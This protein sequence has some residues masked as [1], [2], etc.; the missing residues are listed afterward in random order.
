MGGNHWTKTIPEMDLFSVELVSGHLVLHLNLGSGAIRV[1]ASRSRL[2]DKQ[3]H[4]MTLYRDGKEGT[5][6]VDGVT[7]EFV[8]PGEDTYLDLQGGLYLGGY[9]GSFLS[10]A[11]SVWSA[12]LQHGFVGCVQGLHVDGHAIDIVEFARHQDVDD[13]SV[14]YNGSQYTLIT[15]PHE[16]QSQVE[17]IVLRFR[18]AR[19]NGFLFSTSSEES[20]DRLQAA[21]INGRLVVTIKVGDKDKTIHSGHNLHDN[22][23]HSLKYT[24]RVMNLLIQLDH[25]PHV[26]SKYMNLVL[27]INLGDGPVRIKDYARTSINDNKWHAISIT[28]PYPNVH[29]LSVDDVIATAATSSMAATLDL[30]SLFYIG[31][32]PKEVY[33]T[34]PKDLHARHGFEGCLASLEIN[35]NAPDLTT[36][37][38]IPSSL[39]TPG[40]LGHNNKCSQHVCAN[41][42]VCVQ[43][44]NSFT[45]DCDMTSYT[46]PTCS[47]ESVAYEF[48]PERGIITFV[49]P[50]DRRPEMKSD[51]LAFAFITNHHDAVI[52]RVESATSNDYIEVEIVE[53]NIFVVYNMGTN[54]NPIGETFVKV[55]DGFYHVV[56][57]TRNAANSTLQLDDFNLQTN[58]PSGNQLSVFNSVGNIQIGGKWNR[59]KQRI[60]RPFSGV[61][62]GLVLNGQR[63]LDLAADKDPR[64]QIRGD[65]TL[66]TS[67][68]ERIREPLLQKMQQTPPDHSPGGSDDLVFS[69]AGSGCPNDDEDSC[70]PSFDTSPGDDLITPVYVPPTPRSKKPLEPQCRDDDED[71][72]TDGSG[73]DRD[74]ISTPELPSS[75]SPASPPPSPD[76][77]SESYPNITIVLAIQ[78]LDTPLIRTTGHFAPREQRFVHHAITFRS[79]QTYVAL[80]T[81]QAFQSTSIYFQLKTRERDALLL[82]NAGREADFLAVELVAGHVQ[83]II[84]LGDG[85]VRIAILLLTKSCWFFVPSCHQPVEDCWL[86]INLGDGPV[87]IKDYAR[88][89]INDNKWHAISIT[90]P[91]PNVHS[92]S[93][94]DVIATAATSS[95][96]ATLDL[97]SLFYIGDDRDD[98]STP[99]LPSRDDRD[100]V[101]TPELPSS[102]SPASPPPSPDLSSE[103]YP[104]ITEP[105][106]PPDLS[107]ES[108]PNITEPSRVYTDV[109]SSSSSSSTSYSSSTT[110]AL[111]TT[112]FNNE[113]IGQQ[114]HT[115]QPQEET[116]G[117]HTGPEILKTPGPQVVT[118]TDLTITNSTSFSDT[119]TSSKAYNVTHIVDISVTHTD[120]T[121]TTTTITSRIN[122]AQS[123]LPP[124]PTYMY[125]PPPFTYPPHVINKNQINSETAE[126]T[127]FVILV[128]AGTLIAII[129]VILL[130]LKLKPPHPPPPFTYPPHVINKNQINSETAEATAFV[131]LVIAGT[132]IAIILVILLI[133]KLKQNTD[134]IYTM[135]ETKTSAVAHGHHQALLS[136]SMMPCSPPP[137]HSGYNNNNMNPN[138]SIYN[139]NTGDVRP[140]KRQAG[141]V[142]EWYV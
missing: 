46:G 36:D 48:G 73:D 133:L 118:P 122:V 47:D 71:C 66:V 50:E 78:T 92:L 123:P 56:R 90:R 125:P 117:T 137:L 76:L 19:P 10:S 75:K 12:N 58:F 55:N 121:T 3:W 54:D 130:I 39:T 69:G 114:I 104:N 59:S 88:T 35:G 129:L 34:L 91:Y 20:P 99:E 45:C 11:P 83:L 60:E 27:I 85:P 94:D 97:T 72:V 38:L 101:S 24:R 139:S 126:A 124:P 105:S 41:R 14:S 110:T 42:G 16:V 142:K 135:D 31:G 74:D 115:T 23:W 109:T 102:K 52:L 103:S 134:H 68:H 29:S 128:I 86:I 98:V 6:T 100:D 28:R 136:N 106:R 80:P 82:Y 62:A 111:S 4:E 9:G 61:I 112:V 30:T 2:D 25:L 89:S 40:C 63:V 26:K 79:R 107:S 95:M 1:K 108:Y 81:L 37:P 131:I 127:A 53:G 32:I 18:T 67:L 116:T 15:M 96:A 44:W 49:F 140:M 17:D 84:N 8:C 113:V 70:T 5:I 65:V 87:R 64:T 57:F 13:L 7:T 132:L 141:H 77:S 33:L 119:T 22:L 21:I 120:P 43:Q 51:V 93:V 138:S